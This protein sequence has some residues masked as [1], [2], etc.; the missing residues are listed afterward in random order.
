MTRHTAVAATLAALLAACG[1]SGSSTGNNPPGTSAGQVTK[2]AITSIS[3]GSMVVNGVTFST[4]ATTKVRVEG[5]ER[6]ERP[7]TELRHGMVVRVKG[8]HAN[9]VGEAAEVEFEDHVK[10]K[11]RSRSS[12]PDSTSVDVGGRTVHIEDSTRVVDDRGVDITPSD[13]G[14]DDRVRVSGF[15]DDRG[16][17]RATSVERQ[18]RSSTDD[19]FEAKGYVHAL[20]AGRT[21]FTLVPSPGATAGI[22]VTLGTGVTLV[23]A[24][25]EGSL[26]EVHAPG[27]LSSNAVTASL[28]QLEDDR[29]AEGAEVEVEGIVTSPAPVN[30]ADFRVGG[31]RV[32]TSAST[33]WEFG[34]AGDLAPG[35]KVEAE[36]HVIDA[37]GALAADKVSFRYSVKIEAPL[38]VSGTDL[39][40]LGMPVIDSELTRIDDALVNGGTYEIR[41]FPRRD[42]SGNV[43]AV[44]ATRIR[45]R[46]SGGGGGGG[47][48]YLWQGPVDAKSGTSTLTI[49]GVVVTTVGASFQDH[50]QDGDVTAPPLDRI[51][52]F[53][54]VTV[55]TSVVKARINAAPA[56]APLTAPAD[57]LEIEDEPSPHK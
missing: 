6:T 5:V 4:S 27:S 55:G 3:T 36:G 9:H 38:T 19:S 46:S 56:G 10:G 7:E 39:S 37:S 26:V 35:T 30:A 23:A 21:A 28:V 25:V 12:T 18:S 20:N 44:I 51:P 41:G 49:L 54:K 13:I 43:T 53:A 52:F 15:A 48:R 22:S 45:A 1:G 16:N 17:F 14:P 24:I 47:I 29:E 42:G 40:V 31:Q 33:R 34:T 2:G 11:V 32:T 57:E 50:K 8:N